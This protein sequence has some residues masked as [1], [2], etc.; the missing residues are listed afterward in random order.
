MRKLLP[1]LRWVLL[2]AGI[3]AC[4]LI[5][6]NARAILAQSTWVI[7]ELGTIED[8]LT[9]LIVEGGDQCFDKAAAWRAEDPENRKLAVVESVSNRL[10]RW[11]IAPEDHD[12]AKAILVGLDVPES[13]IIVIPRGNAPINK[14]Y[15]PIR[16]WHADHP[17]HQVGA[18]VTY[19]SVRRRSAQLS[20]DG[21]ASPI[22]FIGL[23]TR[24]FEPDKWYTDQQGIKAFAREALRWGYWHLIGDG[25]VGPEWDEQQWL[26]DLEPASAVENSP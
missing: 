13:E 17:E 26:E 25:Q 5:F 4:V 12:R 2:L 21:D 3:V 24:A 7:A 10:S 14:S 16:K 6:I 11:G 9:V 15:V 23:P 8:D 19:L 1:K 18:L 20:T 22:K